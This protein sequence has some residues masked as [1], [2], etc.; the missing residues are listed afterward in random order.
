MGCDTFCKDGL[1]DDK[2]GPMLARYDRNFHRL[3]VKCGWGYST[4]YIL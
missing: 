1:H 2:R 3:V 4:K